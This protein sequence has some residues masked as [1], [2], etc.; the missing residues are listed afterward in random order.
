MLAK[1]T[2][3]MSGWDAY[4]SENR[5]RDPGDLWC[6]EGNNWGLVGGTHYSDSSGSLK[7][8]RILEAGLDLMEM[9][10]IGRSRH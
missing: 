8:V 7:Y 4:R 2:L 1:V 9:V 6:N 10:V 5:D 3:T